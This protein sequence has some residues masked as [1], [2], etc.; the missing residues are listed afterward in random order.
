MDKV[1]AAISDPTRRSI[2][3]A[4]AVSSR[5]AG[6]LAAMFPLSRPA[7]SRHLRVLRESGLVVDRAIGRR[8]VYELRAEALAELTMWLSGF[9]QA[10]HVGAYL[11]ALA[12]EVHRAARDHRSRQSDMEETA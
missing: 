9:S 12:T 8:R 11:D 10:R 7:I 5:S 4:L 3:E 2:L 6:Q 1:A